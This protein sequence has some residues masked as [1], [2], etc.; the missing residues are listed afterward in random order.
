MWLC[1]ATS[2][3][4]ARATAALVAALAMPH[5]L[6]A[7][8]DTLQTKDVYS[9]F[10]GRCIAGALK[11]GS[12][13]QENKDKQYI[14]VSKEAAQYKVRQVY[15]HLE[16]GQKQAQIGDTE[17]GSCILTHKHGVAVWHAT[18][19]CMWCILH[20]M[21]HPCVRNCLLVLTFLWQVT[22]AQLMTVSAA[23]S[24]PCMVHMHMPHCQQHQEPQ[25]CQLPANEKCLPGGYRFVS[26][27]RLTQ[28]PTGWSSRRE[29]ITL[30]SS[31]SAVTVCST[32]SIGADVT[33]YHASLP[34]CF[35]PN[36]RV[37][38]QNLFMNVAL[39]HD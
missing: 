33:Y 21:R 25:P 12:T 9:R 38:M 10:F 13:L 28:V 2:G 37:L 31:S 8:Y 15:H 22:L 6:Q 1:G 14:L 23:C 20:H 4:D 29:G 32:A 11:P 24:S 27:W 34:V 18:A 17:H 3:S 36:A 26:R 35:C 19:S 5:L 16:L 30:V 39:A 7:V